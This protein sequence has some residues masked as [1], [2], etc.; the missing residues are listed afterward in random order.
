[1]MG[2]TVNA[3]AVTDA[4]AVPE[5]VVVTVLVVV[6]D[7]VWVAWMV[8]DTVIGDRVNKMCFFGIVIQIFM[9]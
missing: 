7:A 2:K 8:R 1:M 9:N 4:V 6:V 5:A 3:V